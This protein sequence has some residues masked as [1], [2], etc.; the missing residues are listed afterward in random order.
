MLGAR[1]YS[2]SCF[3]VVP[4]L[5]AVGLPQATQGLWCLPVGHLTPFLESCPLLSFKMALT[6][7]RFVSLDDF[8]GTAKLD[9]LRAF[10]MKQA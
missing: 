2:A 6:G 4:G 10:K 3:I 5:L 1:W 7:T 8:K 9:R